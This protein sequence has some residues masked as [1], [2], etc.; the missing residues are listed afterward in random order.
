MVDIAERRQALGA[1]SRAAR[2]RPRSAMAVGALGVATSGIFIGLSG[3]SPATATFFRCLLALPLLWPL[4]RAERTT[5]R[6]LP[7][8]RGAIAA[9]AGVL[10]AADAL[11]WTQ[12]IAEVGAG[13]TAVL[14]N[15]QVVVVPLLA[16]LIDREPVRRTFLVV[17]PFMAAGILLAGGILETGATGSAP[18]RGTAHALLAA[19]CYAAFLFLLRRGGHGGQVM[20]SYRV[21]LAS[22]AVVGAVWPGVTYTPGWGPLGWLALTAVSGQIGGWLLIALATSHLSS[23]A[24]AAMLLLTPVGAI[25]LAAV[26]LGEHPTMPQLLGCALILA[27]AYAAS[28]SGSARRRIVVTVRKRLS[29]L[30]GHAI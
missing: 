14:V 18:A 20:Q 12:A 21:V 6:A 2:A 16:L 26:V 28:T 29:V 23:T 4:A 8:R 15:A 27:C 11:L 3:A 13:L 25:G 5:E 1:V 7:W 30:R 17:L 22:A 19:L 24:S 9:V 10:F